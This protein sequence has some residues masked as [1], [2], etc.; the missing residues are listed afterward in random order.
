M[1][2]VIK[3]TTSIAS[4]HSSKLENIA[5]SDCPEEDIPDDEDTINIDVNDNYGAVI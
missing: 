4:L 5:N 1:K 2:Q 3:S